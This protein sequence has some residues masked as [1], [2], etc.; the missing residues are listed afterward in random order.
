MGIHKGSKRSKEGG[1]CWQGSC[2][3]QKVASAALK[4][5][6]QKDEDESIANTII[7]NIVSA[8]HPGPPTPH[9][10]TSAHTKFLPTLRSEQ[11]KPEAHSVPASDPA[12]A[13]EQHKLAARALKKAVKEVQDKA[14]ATQVKATVAAGTGA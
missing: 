14:V 2:I 12:L 9:T 1:C 4:K 7:H 11:H 10:Q 5:A 8:M 6:V 3:E 13:R